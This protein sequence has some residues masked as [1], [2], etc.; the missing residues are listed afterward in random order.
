MRI[1]TPSAKQ[2]T[3]ELKERNGK[4]CIVT[5]ELHRLAGAKKPSESQKAKGPVDEESGKGQRR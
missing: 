3:K 1:G 4:L 2:S 5:T